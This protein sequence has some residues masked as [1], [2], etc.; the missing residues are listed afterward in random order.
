MEK[1]FEI[2]G[3]KIVFFTSLENGNNAFSFRAITSEADAN[4]DLVEAEKPYTMNDIMYRGGYVAYDEYYVSFSDFITFCVKNNVFDNETAAA[5]MEAWS[6][7]INKAKGTNIEVE[8]NDMAND[9]NMDNNAIIKGY[10]TNLGKYNE[11]IL[12][13]KLISFPISD[14]E[15]N[16]AL[17]E[18]GCK[19][20]DENGVVH[21]PLY[22]EYFFSD[23]EC[24]IPFE[25]SEYE[26]VENLNIIAE[27]V[28]ALEAYEQDVLKVIMEGHTSDVDEALRIVEDNDYRTWDSCD[29]MADVA[30]R[31]A[32]EFG[33]LNDVPERL[34]YYIDY[35][36]W[37]RD[38][39]LEGTFLEGDGFFVEVFN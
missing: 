22:E 36:K 17:K 34:Q 1:K 3:V 33:D 2:N 32:A 23:W 21:N 28:E 24:E 20:V 30:E 37:G 11:G 19:Y 14:E 16:E 8:A 29:N 27:R 12:S 35:E 10:I 6:N 18:I 38:L 9:E 5:I 13:Y 39:K 26:S 25:Y 31:M 4:Y 15:L 7:F